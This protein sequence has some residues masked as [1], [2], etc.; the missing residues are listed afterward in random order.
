LAQIQGHHIT[1][2]TEWVVEL[3]NL[4]HRTISR[5]QNT[6]ATPQSFADLT[7]FMHAVAYEWNRMRMEL[8]LGTDLRVQSGKE[9]KLIRELRRECRELQKKLKILRQEVRKEKVEN[10]KR[11]TENSR[12]SLVGPEGA[13][14][15]GDGGG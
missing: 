4:Q 12:R 6:K 11:K 7:N 9:G 10:G 8:D 2:D 5:I 13:G 15:R 1:Y 14:G 3:G